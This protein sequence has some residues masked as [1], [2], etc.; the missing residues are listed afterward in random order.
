VGENEKS[1]RV[2]LYPAVADSVNLPDFS[3]FKSKAE[4]GFSL[5][6]AD[7]QEDISKNNS[8]LFDRLKKCAAAR[9]KM[10][11]AAVGPVCKDSDITIHVIGRRSPL[12]RINQDD[13][14]VIV[15]VHWNLMIPYFSQITTLPIVHSEVLDIFADAVFHYV[16]LMM[17]QSK[18][19]KNVLET[20][21]IDAWRGRPELLLA[22]L[23]IFN[24]PNIY[25]IRP[26]KTWLNRI[27]AVNDAY[28]LEIDVSDAAA[29]SRVN[30]AFLA[31]VAGFVHKVV[32]NYA[33]RY[34]DYLWAQ[35]YKI[36]FG[37]RSCVCMVTHEEKDIVINIH[38][39]VHQTEWKPALYLSL[40]YAIMLSVLRSSGKENGKENIYLAMMKTW[41]RYLSF[42]EHTERQQACEVYG[43]PQTTLE[44]QCRA[45]SENI[46]GNHGLELVE[47]FLMLVN[48]AFRET[49]VEK[50]KVLHEQY[51]GKT[52][53]YFEQLW[54]KVRDFNTTL[55]KNNIN[56]GKLIEI[57]RSDDIDHLQVAEFL[58]TGCLDRRIVADVNDWLLLRTLLYDLINAPKVFQNDYKML[59]KVL[60][61][62]N[63]S[64]I[65]FIWSLGLDHDP[66]YEMVS[67][68]ISKL[69]NDIFVFDR[70]KIYEIVSDP[71]E[72]LEAEAVT[73][74]LLNWA[75]YRP[76]VRRSI[77]K[78][79]LT[80]L[81]KNVVLQLKVL[82]T[83]DVDHLIRVMRT[84]AIGL[85]GFCLYQAY[86]WGS[87]GDELTERIR[88]YFPQLLKKAREAMHPAATIKG[89][90]MLLLLLA[91]IVSD[92]RDGFARKIVITEEERQT[93]RDLVKQCLDWH[94]RHFVMM[95]AGMAA[96]YMGTIDG[97]VLQQFD[98][99]LARYDG[100]DRVMLR[101]VV[102]F[103]VER[104]IE[105]V[106]VTAREGEESALLKKI[107]LLR[108]GVDPVVSDQANKFLRVMAS[109]CDIQSPDIILKKKNIRRLLL[110]LSRRMKTQNRY[111]CHPAHL[112]TTASSV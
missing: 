31:E 46:I 86:R 45:L 60:T 43:F 78:D 87:A 109:H 84:G 41:N 108:Y 2:I 22:M 9:L 27:H 89:G 23:D 101:S 36:T 95:V 47:D 53:I 94:Q 29:D 64:L 18:T 67:V 50:L 68:Y 72:C 24:K 48:Y 13:H 98:M 104:L 8:V 32:K 7:A 15:V 75:G 90:A 85:I 5:L 19:A 6:P 1:A 77:I 44:Q 111:F 16:A 82:T 93:V 83:S 26:T 66:R 106:L 110:E 42:D 62:V 80:N 33:F 74:Y 63:K 39:L 92:E 55:M 21:F 71:M 112:R 20:I 14:R 103:D 30:A 79:T 76:D 12:L 57:L 37:V 70:V 51:E 91:Q 96:G 107:Q 11:H 52:G 61:K 59:L 58:R 100:G 65:V 97:W 54:N 56:N 4:N 38:P 88:S 35:S 10:L 3:F 99:L 17:K 28:Q 105:R 49:F 81:T 25:H 40:A 102:Q 69:M 73:G 34:A